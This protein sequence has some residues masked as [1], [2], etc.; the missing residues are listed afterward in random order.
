M[1]KRED[2]QGTYLGNLNTDG[3]INYYNTD[4]GIQTEDAKTKTQ[5]ST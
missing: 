1:G 2:G 5:M 3:Q 4:R